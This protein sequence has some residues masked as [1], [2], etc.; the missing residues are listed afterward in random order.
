MSDIGL[1]SDCFVTSRDK[2]FNFLQ[3]LAGEHCSL[4]PM[5]EIRILLFSS[6]GSLENHDICDACHAFPLEMPLKRF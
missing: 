4:K 5:F 6:R 3:L 2:T 1:L